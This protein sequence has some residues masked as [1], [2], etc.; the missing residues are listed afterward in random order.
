MTI[1]LLGVFIPV[2][3]NC[4]KCLKVD[5]MYLVDGCILDGMYFDAFFWIPIPN[6]NVVIINTFISF[7]L[8][9]YIS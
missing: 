3:F 1:Y 7:W 6:E 8:R 9:H 5:V 4:D 2:F